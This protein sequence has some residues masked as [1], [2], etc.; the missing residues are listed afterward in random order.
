MVW[1]P[2]SVSSSIIEGA[3]T[4]QDRH[5]LSW[6][7]ALIVSAAQASDCRYLL[8]E[9]LQGNQLLE[10]VEVINPFTTDPDTFN[11]PHCRQARPAAYSH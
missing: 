8:T 5:G 1:R 10:N 3:W 2:L 11:R 4:M 6:W 7:D 9:D